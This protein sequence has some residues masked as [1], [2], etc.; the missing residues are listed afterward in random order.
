MAESEKPLQFIPGASL[1]ADERKRQ[2]E[3]EGFSP[4]DHDMEYDDE[5]SALAMAAIAYIASATKREVLVRH[6]SIRA[7]RGGP[8]EDGDDLSAPVESFFDP[9][10]SDWCGEYSQDGTNWDK[11]KKHSRLR[12]LVIA[13]ALVAAEIDRL[14]RAT[15]ANREP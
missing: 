12:Q 4:E 8:K 10:P 15:A 7:S 11:R 5:G 14:Q 13:G 1:I 3:Q 6:A 9:F 2:V